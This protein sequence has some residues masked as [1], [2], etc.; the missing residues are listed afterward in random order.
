MLFL[1][2]ELLCKGGK[3]DYNLLIVSVSISI[4]NYEKILGREHVGIL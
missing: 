3:H 2:V 1:A 4:Q